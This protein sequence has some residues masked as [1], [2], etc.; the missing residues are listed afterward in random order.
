MEKA[1]QNLNFELA[2]RYRD[3]ISSLETIIEKQIVRTSKDREMD[4]IAMAR[5]KDVISM[6]VFI[7]RSGK[8]IDREH[9]ILGDSIKGE[10]EEVFSSFIQ[11]FYFDMAFVPREIVLQK[12]PSDS[13]TLVEYLTRIKG[14]KVKFS[15]PKKGE[16]LKLV[17]LVEKNAKDSLEKHLAYLRRRER[18]RPRGLEELEKLLGISPLS[19]IECYD[20]SNISGVQSVGSMVVYEKKQKSLG[21]YRKFKIKSVEGPN[22]YASHQEVLTRRLERLK[23]ENSLGNREVS[24]GRRPSLI[25]I[26]GGKGHVNAAKF[27]MSLVN[28]EEIPICGLYKDEFHNTKGIIYNGAEIPLKVSSD[29][30]R[31]LFDIQEETHRFAINYHRKLR[32]KNMVKSELDEV[33]GIGEVRK[34]AL[35][36]HFKSIEKIKKASITELLEVDKI[37]RKSAENLYNYFNGAKDEGN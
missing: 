32:D 4:I 15:V 34:K 8:I 35:L 14:K 13:D 25:I 5:E 1:S 12:E 21:E 17:E 7:M 16:K 29:I 27:A 23:H 24:F 20:I 28:M 11:Q 22:D 30:Y 10:D 31:F 33:N 18:E 3:N 9:F 26:D 37:D 36:K 2:A 6:Q 19:R